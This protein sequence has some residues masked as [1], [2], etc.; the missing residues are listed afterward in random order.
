MVK[1]HCVKCGDE[2]FKYY[3]DDTTGFVLC[4]DC[5]FGD[6]GFSDDDDVDIEDEEDE[7]EEE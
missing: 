7:E 3:L 4:N 5:Y 1:R 2:V 6:D